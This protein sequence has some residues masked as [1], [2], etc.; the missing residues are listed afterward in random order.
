MKLP[1]T[2]TLKEIAHI[3][4]CKYVG[5]DEHPVTGINEIHVV[6]SGDI[7]F[8]DH[9][10]YYDKALKS[11]A[12][13]VIIN[14]EV[15]APEGKALLLSDEPFRIFNNLTL[16]FSSKQTWKEEANP[17]IHPTAQIAPG[18]V[19]GKNAVIG[20]HTVIHPNVVIYDNAQIGSNVEIHANTSIGSH[21]FYYKKEDG[22]YTKMHSCGSVKIENNVEIGS[23]CSIDKGVT[24]ATVIGEGT[25][26]DNNVHVGHDTVIGQNCLIAAQVG[27]AGCVIIEAGVTLW[28][29]VGVRSDIT[30]GKDAV[31]LAQTGISKGL[32]GGKTYFGSPVAE[33]REKLKELANTRK[34]PGILE[35]IKALK[36]QLNAN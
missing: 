35:D 8:V 21:A 10:K 34:I 36:N 31:V 17:E 33:S 18:V 7:V 30:I 32:E 25:K 1:R 16:H 14:K 6:E 3:A 13:T 22:K 11:A 9:P 23:G 5:G 19:I 15:E 2:Y 24:G 20:A 12:T 29:Q 27:I 4:D 28:G 26:I